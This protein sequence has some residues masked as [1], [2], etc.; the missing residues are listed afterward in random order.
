MHPV[1]PS[2]RAPNTGPDRGSEA[3]SAHSPVLGCF[4]SAGLCRVWLGGTDGGAALAHLSCGGAVLAV[5]LP[6][7]IC[8]CA[9][10]YARVLLSPCGYV[11]TRVHTRV[12]RCAC[13]HRTRSRTHAG[14]ECQN[15]KELD[16]RSVMQVLQRRSEMPLV[17]E[18][19]DHAGGH[20]LEGNPACD[21]HV[22]D[23]LACVRMGEWVDVMFV[24]TARMQRRRYFI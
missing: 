23:L 20:L 9:R 6:A 4:A 7:L 11:H 14:G 16:E 18:L 3:A 15:T 17:T 24:D 22:Q 21:H 10:K 1:C 19:R 5:R 2:K 8:V 13:K 12:H